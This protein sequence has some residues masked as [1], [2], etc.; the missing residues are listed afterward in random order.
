MHYFL[1]IKARAAD[2]QRDAEISRQRRQAR[3]NRRSR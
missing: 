3:D 2:L 1:F